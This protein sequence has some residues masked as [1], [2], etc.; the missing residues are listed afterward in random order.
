MYFNSVIVDTYQILEHNAHHW[1]G[2][3][4]CVTLCKGDKHA[5]DLLYGAAGGETGASQ[6]NYNCTGYNGTAMNRS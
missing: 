2:S 5:N 1:P 4:C 6:H 3:G